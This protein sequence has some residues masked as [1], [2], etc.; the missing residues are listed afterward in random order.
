MH[1]EACE[2]VWI[3]SC[4]MVIIHVLSQQQI[5]R[6]GVLPTAARGRRRQT[7]NYRQRTLE[8]YSEGQKRGPLLVN[9]TANALQSTKF[10]G[11]Q[12]ITGSLVFFHPPAALNL[13]LPINMC[14][15]NGN[16]NGFVE[17][18]CVASW[19]FWRGTTLQLTDNETRHSM[20]TSNKASLIHYQD[21]SVSIL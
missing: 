18:A 2:L 21:K 1:R 4:F 19:T 17:D 20:I 9:S 11:V 8:S 13:H 15:R 16:E 10:L 5:S 7:H 12:V 14:V 3:L 6:W